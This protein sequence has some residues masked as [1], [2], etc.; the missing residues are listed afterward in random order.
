M[1][2]K[3]L[4]L[5]DIPLVVMHSERFYREALRDAGFRDIRAQGFR[6]EGAGPLDLIQPVIGL[7]WLVLPRFVYP[8]SS[9]LIAAATG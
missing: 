6:G 5:A 8:I 7:P 3:L 2:R 4:G 9:R 1:T